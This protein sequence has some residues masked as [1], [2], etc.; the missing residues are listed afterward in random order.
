MRRFLLAVLI[1]VFS[2]LSF[3]LVQPA[4]VYAAGSGCATVNGATFSTAVNDPYI[5]ATLPFSAGDTIVY[6]LSWTIPGF[7]VTSVTV[8]ISTSGGYVAQATFNSSP[9][10]ATVAYTFPADQ[11]TSLRFDWAFDGTGSFTPHTVT[12]TIHCGTDIY[13]GPPIPAGFVLRT[14]TCDVAVFD[15]P[16]GQPVGDNRIKGGQ[17]WYVNPKSV[18][19]ADGQAW[20]EIFVSGTPN[21]YIPTKCVGG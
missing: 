1:I 15:A 2:A 3:V 4:P 7:T 16:G 17:T 12:T 9:T 18:K 20:T 8:Y 6:D 19:A 13:A 11:T 10:S 5:T 21:G 14:I